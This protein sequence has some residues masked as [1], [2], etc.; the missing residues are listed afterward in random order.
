MGSVPGWERSPGEGN[1]NSLQYFC[2]ENPLD[3]GAWWLHVVH[4]VTKSQTGLS[5]WAQARAS[6]GQPSKGDKSHIHEGTST[7]QWKEGTNSKFTFST[8]KG[9]WFVDNFY[10]GW[11]THKS[12]VPPSP[13]FI[14]PSILTS[15]GFPTAPP[16]AFS[17]TQSSPSPVPAVSLNSIAV[18]I[19]CRKTL[20][21]TSPL[22]S[23]DTI[24]TDY[25]N[26]QGRSHCSPPTGSQSPSP[27]RTC[28]LNHCFTILQTCYGFFTILCFHSW[29]AHLLCAKSVSGT[30]PGAGDEQTDEQGTISDFLAPA[31]SASASLYAWNAALFPCPENAQLQH[32]SSKVTL[33]ISLCQLSWAELSCPTLA[34][35]TSALPVVKVCLS[36]SCGHLPGRAAVPGIC[37]SHHTTQ[38]IVKYPLNVC[39]NKQLLCA[40]YCFRHLRL[41]PKQDFRLLKG[42]GYSGIAL[43]IPRCLN[44][45][46]ST[47]SGNRTESEGLTGRYKTQR[48]ESLH[49]QP[50][51]FQVQVHHQMI[52]V[53]H[54]LGNG[55]KVRKALLR[56]R[57]Q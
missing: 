50:L 44:I 15:C 18:S 1:G 52:S 10:F 41:P 11:T 53:H 29:H 47:W 43:V 22:L 49:P 9:I 37:S 23:W 24:Q 30:V 45:L 21:P 32:L 34:L 16:A 51:Q 26:L 42:K 46:L 4:G 14:W 33:S 13:R 19:H 7:L 35:M 57:S 20:W 36:M 6:E 27:P 3:R 54:I 25:Y 39:W 40:G 17:P 56:L 8:Q 12:E 38:H 48:S 5:R 55:T 31:A 2:L 28:L